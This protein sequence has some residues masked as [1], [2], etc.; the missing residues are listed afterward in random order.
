[1]GKST[2]LDLVL[3]IILGSVLSRAITGE[4]PLV[5]TL[6]ASFAMVILHGALATIAFHSVAFSSLIKGN[7]EVLIA[8]GQLNWT[9]VRKSLIGKP[10]LLESLRAEGRLDDPAKV[11]CARL[12]RSGKIS[13]VPRPPE[14]RVVTIAVEDG[15]KLVR[16]EIQ[17]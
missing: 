14:P 11:A 10:D 8:D 3:S 7:D 4:S 6:V 17:S 12:E 9:R 1:M 16:I 5:P 15:V 2:P 13:V